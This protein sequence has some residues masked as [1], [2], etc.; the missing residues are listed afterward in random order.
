MQSKSRRRVT[1][2]GLAI[3]LSVATAA[4]AASTRITAIEFRGSEDPALI[5]LRGDGPLSVEKKENVQDNQVVL[6]IKDATISPAVA[7]KIDTSSFDS[8]VLLIS[9]YQSGDAV[10]VVVQLRGPAAS[11]LETDGRLARL[12][13]ARDGAVAPSAEAAG[14]PTESASSAEEKSPESVETTASALDEKALA[15]NGGKK[16]KDAA[17]I[18]QFF[19][20]REN[21]KYV[22]RPIT[23]QVREMEVSDVFRLIAE[24][25]GFNIILSD[26][27]KGKLT[28]SL[29]DVPWDQALAVVLQT[30]G[31]GAERSNNILRVMT[32]QSLTREKQLELQARQATQA[33]SPRVTRVFPVSYAK[34]EDLA[35]LLQEFQRPATGAT[36]ASAAALAAAPGAALS[37]GG[38]GD[39]QQSQAI[40]ADARTNSIIVRDTEENLERIQKLIEILDTET[41]QVS[42]EGKVV[43]ASEQFASVISGNLGSIM[44][45]ANTLATSFN[46]TNP[47]LDLFGATAPFDATAPFP[48]ATTGGGRIGVAFLP[49]IRKMTA[50][51]DMGERENK[52]RLV[53]SPKTV[54]LNKQKASVVQSTPIAVPITTVT[55]ASTSET[56]EFKQANLSL[57]VTPTVTNDGSVI[58]DLALVRD[59]IVPLGTTSGIANRKI[60]TQVVVDSGTTLVIGGFYSMQN[61]SS[62]S[63]FPFLRKLPLI[64]ALFGSEGDQMDRS[65]LFFFVTPQILNPKKSGFAT[66]GG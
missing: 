18:E 37:A 50:V 56:F 59:V 38:G 61:S 33:V 20:A 58:L 62:S 24:T 47:S 52:L 53:S 63:G 31:L 39:Q 25:S 12:K 45:G 26:E 46:G 8:K 29:V 5:E 22:G 57:D 32:L 13:I 48:L 41:P 3:A 28:L 49:S 42:I 16:D 51:L 11:E 55:T 6:E 17:R 19:H 44:S 64:G 40:L 7:R 54:V 23:L 27:V 66:N 36:A 35:K 2:L 4:S 15:K 14:S 10:R 60:N 65:E 30:L 34:L 21:Q 1:A 43:E 9:P